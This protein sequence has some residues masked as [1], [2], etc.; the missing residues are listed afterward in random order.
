MSAAAAAAAA[1]RAAC[2]SCAAF[3]ESFELDGVLVTVAGGA[4]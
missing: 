4:G 3:L 2:S 1:S